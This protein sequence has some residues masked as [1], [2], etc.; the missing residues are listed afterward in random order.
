MTPHHEGNIKA[1][2]RFISVEKSGGSKA[3][4]NMP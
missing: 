4:Q 2:C 3:I 1:C